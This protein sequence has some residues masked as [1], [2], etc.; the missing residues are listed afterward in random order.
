MQELPTEG[1][2]LMQ[3]FWKPENEMTIEKLVSEKIL[4]YSIL[5]INLPLPP[6]FVEVTWEHGLLVVKPSSTA[7]LAKAVS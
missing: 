1:S 2:R 6:Q 4:Q 3:D 5:Y 7:E